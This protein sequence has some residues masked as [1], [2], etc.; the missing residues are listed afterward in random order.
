MLAAPELA[1][2]SAFDGASIFSPSARLFDALDG[3]AYIGGALLLAS[4]WR[5]G[6]SA[7]AF[8]DFLLPSGHVFAFMPLGLSHF[9]LWGLIKM[10]CFRLY[11]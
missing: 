9:R 6:L 1:K 10:A 2:V 8:R 5:A 4:P 7:H 3:C 11:D